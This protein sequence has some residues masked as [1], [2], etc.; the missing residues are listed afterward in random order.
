MSPSRRQFLF[1]AAAVTT[2]WPVTALPQRGDATPRLFA[3]GV[4][5]GD[6]LTDR[7]VLWTRV[8][9][10]PATT[11]PVD[12]LWTIAT[13]E[14]FANTAG[15][16]TVTTSAERDYTVKVDAGGLQPGRPYFY[17]FETRG[18]RSPIG[19]TRTLPAGTVQRARLAVVSCS[20]YPAGYFNVFRCLA[21]RA[22]LDAVLHVGDYI[23][24]FA[25]G[26]YGDG[27]ASGRVP[28]RPGEAVTLE[29]YRS[30]YASY[31]TDVDLQEAHRL[32]PF[33]LVWD[34]HESGDDAWAGGSKNHAANQGE[35]A[36]RF[37]AAQRAYLEWQPIR[38]TPGAAFQ[39]YR[40]FSFGT[41]ADLV[42]LDTRSFRDRQLP[43]NDPAFTAPTRTMLGSA[44]EAWLFDELRT[45]QRGGR[46]WRLIGQGV[47]FS[48]MT[49]PGGELPTPDIWD[50]YPAA[51]GRIF[52]V[53]AA[54]RVRDVAI[55][56]GDRHSSWA[57]DIARDPWK[58]YQPRTG[59]GSAAIELLTPAISSPPLFADATL[60]QATTLLRGVS[61][62][63]QFLE[64]DHNGYVL[65]EVTPNRLLS[66]WHFVPNV[67]ERSPAESRAAAFVCE[68]GS[69]HL[70]PA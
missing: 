54:E 13:D 48:P 28:L 59:V 55:L 42:M 31:R 58:G 8:S 32:H 47:P 51:R 23:Y 46:R 50:G 3:H 65:V 61:P 18:E 57:I 41:L 22:D 45:S 16:G 29:D 33:I 34:D 19:R 7:V 69:S 62:H 12:V 26:R 17:A 44:Q 25:N 68:H 40:R 24:E 53:L 64:G 5:S 4:A 1:T 35:W 36:V 9:P 14:R 21:N 56:T 70:V 66:E 49:P 63:V 43:M 10:P 67:T 39:L 38:E 27:T 60:K 15:R 37:A 6:P 11:G 20:N 52:D 2:A 30:R